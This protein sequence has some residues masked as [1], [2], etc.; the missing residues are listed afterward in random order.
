MFVRA[1]KTVES[2]FERLFTVCGGVVICLVCAVAA[3]RLRGT[4][5]RRLLRQMVFIGVQTFPIA[6]VFGLFTGMIFSL[7]LGLPLMDF[8]VEDRIGTALGVSLVR[9]LAPVFTAFILAA[10][11]GASIAAELGT[12][13]VSEEIDS[14]RV[15]GI[16][17]NRYLA[18]PR[19]VGAILIS[20]LL[21][22]YSC[23]AGMIGGLLLARS[24]FNV[25]STMFWTRVLESVDMKEI[26]TG[27][28][29]A[30]VFAALYSSICVYFGM[31]TRGGAEGVGRS[32]TRAVV[33]SLS[34][35][36]VADFLLTRALFG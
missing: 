9:E 21:T 1:W 7:N 8:G 25:G 4:D 15:M 17:P 34:A 10:R 12:M 16:D 28:L 2:S 23:A 26:S 3:F 31:T 24:Y 11:V 19:I 14:L 6:I 36:L 33:V 27:L 32:T 20:P 30:V 18:M 13:S 5:L 22:V 35:I 29:K